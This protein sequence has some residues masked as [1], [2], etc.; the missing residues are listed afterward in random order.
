MKKL[1]KFV[2]IASVSIIVVFMLEILFIYL[3][4]EFLLIFGRL[5]SFMLNG[6]V[7][8]TIV[9]GSLLLS[10]IFLIVKRS[11]VALK[12]FIINIITSGALVV[13]VLLILLSFAEAMS[14]F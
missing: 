7:L 13:T 3:D 5:V 6:A 12:F 8:Y 4:I 10:T 9:F 11:K 14:N 1:V 2:T